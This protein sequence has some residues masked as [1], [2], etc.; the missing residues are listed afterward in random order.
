M[1]ISV[2]APTHVPAMTGG[3]ERLIDGIIKHLN[4]T[5]E[6]VATLVTLPVREDNLIDLIDAYR[7]FAELDVSGADLVISSK[8]P[9]WM[10]EHPNHA[11]YMMH[12]LRGLYDTYHLFGLPE[13]STG[14]PGELASLQNELKKANPDPRSIF[15]L[16]SRAVDNLG[17]SHPAF[18]FPGPLAGS[19]CIPWMPL[20]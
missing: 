13:T 5:T 12:P 4:E 14:L 8:Y 7:Q 15:D 19:S 17:P 9:A 20:P 18:T 16:F 11:V 3:A 1:N 6:H 2:I 10:V